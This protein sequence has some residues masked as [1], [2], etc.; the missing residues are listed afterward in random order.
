M[1]TFEAWAWTIGICAVIGV[2][3]KLF[4]VLLVVPILVLLVLKILF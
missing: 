1:T 2:F 3:H 4:R